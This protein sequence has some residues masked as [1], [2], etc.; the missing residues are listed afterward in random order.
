VKKIALEEHFLPPFLTD[1]WEPTVAGMPRAT[2][3][4]IRSRLDDTGTR[5]LDDMDAAG[6]DIAVLSVAGPGV[7]VVRDIAEATGLARRANEDLAR[8]VAAKPD[9]YAGFAHVALQDP[10]AAADELER[11]VRDYGFCGALINGQTLGH[12]LDEDRFFPFWERAEALRVPVYLHPADPEKTYAALDG[13][14]QLRRPTWEWTVET[15]T[16]A[17]RM[18]FNGTFERFPEAQLILGHMGETLPYLLWRFDSRAMLYREPGDPRPLPSGYIRRNIPIT[19]SG[20]FANE[21][22]NCAIAALGEDRVM[23]AADYP[24]EDGAVAGRFLDNAAIS[25][26]ARLKVGR[27]NAERLLRLPRR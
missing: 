20:V 1:Q 5:R 14:R 27:S 21:P 11:C 19:I 3:D 2:Y 15:A 16:H 26:A 25:D 10:A 7:Q 18:V 22:L 4:L 6:I 9:R 13:Q 24:F 12:Y 23:F 8:R 17:L